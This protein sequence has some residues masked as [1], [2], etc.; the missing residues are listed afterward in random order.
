M[1]QA[2]ARSHGHVHRGGPL[3]WL[4]AIFHVGGHEHA[5]HDVS[6][7][8]AFKT[9]EGIRTVWIALAALGL[10]TILQVVIV[11]ISGSVALLADT[12][13]NLGDALNSIPLLFAFYLARRSATRSYTYDYGRAYGYGRAEDVASGVFGLSIV[14]SA[15]YILSRNRSGS[16]STRSRSSGWAGWRQRPSSVSSATRPWP[17]FRSAPAIASAPMRW[18]P[19][20]CTPA[21]TG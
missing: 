13:H 8:P 4:Q 9:S 12:P 14:F 11:L 2:S 17:C 18:S 7:D 16:C 21:S 6:A 3:G 15:G 5:E 19:M 1:R 10:T 20:G